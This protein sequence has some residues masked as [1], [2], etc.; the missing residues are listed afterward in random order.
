M[1]FQ[2]EIENFATFRTKNWLKMVQMVQFEFP[3]VLIGPL[4]SN[5]RNFN[6]E[7]THIFCPPLTDDVEGSS[8]IYRRF[9]TGNDCGGGGGDGKTSMSIEMNRV[10]CIEEEGHGCQMAIAKF[11]D[12][13]ILALRA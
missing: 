9:M 1:D 13:M 3:K 12:C 11:L 5:H 6:G 7:S 4:E 10:A 8:V 2:N